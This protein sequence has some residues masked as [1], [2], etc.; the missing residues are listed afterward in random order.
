MKAPRIFLIHATA[1]A[2]DPIMA[3]FA[4][5]WPEA[6]IINLLED[7]LSRDRVEEGELTTSMK[8]RFLTLSQYAV[9][10]AADAI[11]FTCSAFGDAIDLCKPDIA[12]PVLK[13]NEAMIN[14]ALTQASRVAV[15]A[16]FE[17]TITSI[18]T[19]F[20]QVAERSGRAMEVVPYFVPG[21]MQ[22]LSEGNKDGHDT[23][24]AEM[25]AQVGAC[26]L[27]CFAQFSMTSAAGQAQARSGLPVL[28][29]PD[30]AVLELRKMLQAD[31]FVS[32]QDG[33]LPNA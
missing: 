32:F 33:W 7:S 26:D 28:T 3:A 4:R 22:A 31:D 2:I 8:A 23:A 6:Q 17:P 5:Q 25:A 30:S 12:I 9:Q 13:P 1:L 27:I 16:T 21:A 10:C 29:T 14:L 18:I 24:I 15:L 11:L 20:K 19:E